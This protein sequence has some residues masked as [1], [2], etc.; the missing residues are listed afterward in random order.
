M[1]DASVVLDAGLADGGTQEAGYDADSAAGEPPPGPYA[2]Q[3]TEV[4]GT[5]ERQCLAAGLGREGDRCSGATDCGA[6]R[7]GS[8]FTLLLRGHWCVRSRQ[9]LQCALALF[10]RRLSR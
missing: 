6:G 4:L 3:L 7:C 1:L 8:L 10:G 2:C 9:V 5:T